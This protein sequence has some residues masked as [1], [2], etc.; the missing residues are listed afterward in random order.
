MAEIYRA[1]QNAHENYIIIISSLFCLLYAGVWDDFMSPVYY[2]HCV[3][4]VWDDFMSPVYYKHC[5]VGVWD[6]FMSP[7]YYKHCVVGVWDDFMSP[8]YYKHCVVNLIA[9][10][11]LFLDVFVQFTMP[12]DGMISRDHNGTWY[13]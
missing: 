13:F 9:G 4:G 7:V 2:K 6:D 5:V 12:R 10:Q 3:V 8:V 1:Q 11:S